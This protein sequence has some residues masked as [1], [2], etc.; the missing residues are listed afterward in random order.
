MKL[1]GLHSTDVAEAVTDE[2]KMVERGIFGS[3][4]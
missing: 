3:F 4:S 1:K 2:L